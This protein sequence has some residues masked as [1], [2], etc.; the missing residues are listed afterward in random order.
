M[1]KI[2]D[3]YFTQQRPILSGGNHIWQKE[4]RLQCQKNPGLN[5]GS[6][7]LWLYEFGQG[8][9]IGFLSFSWNSEA[10]CLLQG[11]CLC[12][13]PDPVHGWLLRILQISNHTLWG[14]A[15][16]S[17]VLW[18]ADSTM[19][20]GMQEIDLRMPLGIIPVKG[21]GK[22]DWTER[23]WAAMQSLQRTQPIS[24]KALKRD[25]SS[26]LSCIEA[27]GVGLCTPH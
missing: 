9:Y 12:F 20:A 6:T 4:H 26:D 1:I 21:W 11:F 14:E 8:S 19:L 24:W 10:P 5:P 7:P 27:R 3:L 22:V 18:V 25:G 15:V 17:H 23:S 13:L 16:F 2:E